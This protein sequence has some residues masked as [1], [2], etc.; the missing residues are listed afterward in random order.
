MLEEEK[1]KKIEIK[2]FTVDDIY[3]SVL[4]AKL[5]KHEGGWMRFEEVRKTFEPTGSVLMDALG[6]VLL[7]DKGIIAK[8]FAKAVGAKSWV[9]SWA[10]QWLTG[11]TLYEFLN[12]YRL[13]LACEWLTCTD[14]NIKEI[15]RRSGYTSQSKLTN[16]FAKR[17]GCTPREY[18][19]ANRP[20]NYAQL[21]EWE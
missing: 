17:F 21:Y 12:Q 14:V 13:K 15:A 16:M 3:V 8:D 7:E 20:A 1:M 18:R 5:V 10:F 11:M 19:K 9:M 6:Q 4:K 2:R